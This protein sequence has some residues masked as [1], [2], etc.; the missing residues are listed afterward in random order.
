MAVKPLLSD[1]ARATVR[2]ATS[3]FFTGLLAV[4]PILVTM[5]FVMW[6]IGAAESVL[7]GMLSIVLPGDAYRRG[8]GL[9]VA[10][11]MIFVVGLAM[12]GLV[13]KQV[14][15]WL[16][17]Y[18]HKIPL[19][20]TIYGAVRDLTHLISNQGGQKLGRV[21][22]LQWPGQPIRLVGFITVEDLSRFEIA[23][24]EECVAVYLP[25]SYQIGGYTAFIP[26]KLLTPLDMTLED[27]MRFVVTAGVS[28][29]PPD[30]DTRP[31]QPPSAP[32]PPL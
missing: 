4:L 29:S 1:A 15:A 3:I 21:V 2:K 25:M 30:L 8:M 28:R 24:E 32:T 22:M 13:T 20:K 23:A 18:L 12:Q 26:R 5:S 27:A 10:I 11:V 7:G 17:H 6:L 9:V 19:I 14:M 31:P 16:D